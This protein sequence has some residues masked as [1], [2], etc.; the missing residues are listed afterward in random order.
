MEENFG[1]FTILFLP[2]F[3]KFYFKETNYEKKKRKKKNYFEKG[4]ETQS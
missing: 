4:N 3:L 1:S 2:N